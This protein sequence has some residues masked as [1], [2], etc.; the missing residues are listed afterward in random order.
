MGTIFQFPYRTVAEISLPALVR[1]LHTLR[2]LCR[3]EIIPVVKADAYGHGMIPVAKTLV[4]RG[5]CLT[6]AVATLE[7]AI[8]LRKKMPHGVSIL[9]LSGFLP[10]QFD[11]YG[12]YRLTPIIHSLYHLKTLMGRKHLP[13]IHL[14]IDTGMNRLG[15][16]PGQMGE[17]IRTLEKLQ[18]KLA[19]LATHFAESET[20]VSD[21]T[22]QQIA[23]FEGIYRELLAH[24]LL[25]T[26]AKIHIGNSGAIM[27]G[28]LSFSVA[29]RPGA[30]FVRGLAEPEVAG[31]GGS[32]AGDGME[33][34]DS[35]P[36]GFEAERDGRIQ[37]DVCRKEKGEDSLASHRLCGRLSPSA[38]QSRG[39]PFQ[40]SETSYSRPGIDGSDSGGLHWRARR[41]GR[42]TCHFDGQERKDQIG[43]WEIAHWAQTIPYEILCGIS[44]RVPRVY[45]D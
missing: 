36:Q 16:T 8:E 9:V 43:A 29:V 28:K 15:L 45:L 11:A 44:S 32:L 5:S 17:A 24:R 38:Q 23:V 4:S 1:N 39:G 20:T 37:P 34:A 41:E 14:K 18:I 30:Q 2:S 21:F 42:G 26:D 12:K 7:E 40:W 31:L 6:L 27:R 25:N 22:D 19:G 3:K 35:L 10:H 13:E 33:N